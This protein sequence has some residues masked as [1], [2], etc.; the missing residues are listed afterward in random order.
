[1]EQDLRAI[2]TRETLKTIAATTF[3]VFGL[4][5]TLYPTAWMILTSLRTNPE[6]FRSPWGLPEN[7]RWEN[8][9]KA[10][11]LSPIPGYFA[12]SV[13]VSVVSVALILLFG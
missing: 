1:M 3:A 7:L 8:Y 10:F 6:L 2:K 5:V 13:I 12:N 4:I 11:E 9:A